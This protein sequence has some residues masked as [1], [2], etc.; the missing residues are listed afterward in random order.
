MT[1]P[2]VVRVFFAVE[3]SAEMKERVGQY[4]GTLKKRLKS[5]AIRWT[6]PENLHI[7][8]QFLAEV[9]SE[10]LPLLIE[11]VK[12]EVMGKAKNIMLTI[13]AIHVFPNPY[14][15]RVIVLDIAPQTELAAL[16]GWVGSGIRQT[17]YAVEDRPFRGHLTLGRIK[18]PKDLDLSFINEREPPVTEKI[19]LNSIVLFRSEPMPEGSQY[20]VVNRIAFNEKG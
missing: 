7:T 8:L 13:G 16:A 6:K 10:H 4:I 17:N 11:N 14:R 9:Q 2:P 20:T 18:L 12:K 3:L 5:H 1:L 19:D 15:P